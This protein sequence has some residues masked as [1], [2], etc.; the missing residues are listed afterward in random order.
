[1]SRVWTPPPPEVLEEIRALADRPLTREEFEAY[2]NAPMGNE[3]REEILALVAWF[4][5][6]YPTVAERFAY[7]REAYRR[8]TRG[9]TTRGR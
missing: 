6:R 8:Q 3:E 7:V 1:M 5:R 4:T 9:R 2:V